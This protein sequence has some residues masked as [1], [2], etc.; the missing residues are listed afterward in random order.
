MASN[1]SYTLPLSHRRNIHRIALNPKG[2]LLLTVDEDGRAILT[3]FPRRLILYYFT[4]TGPVSALAFSPSG[5]H[6]AVGIGRF[7]EVWRTP[8][9]LDANTEV[10]REY[11]PFLR[12]RVYAGHYDQVQSI[13]WS[14]DSRFFLSA[15]KDLTARV[16]SLNSEARYTPTAL[17]G[18]RESVMAAWFSS[19]Q[20]VV[21]RNR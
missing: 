16:W 5:R 19:D 14:G 6:L 8:W 4:F 18:H 10:A 13:E 9:T 2:N 3:N 12:H 21:S 11:A 17:A 20:E 15:G 1:K 7:V